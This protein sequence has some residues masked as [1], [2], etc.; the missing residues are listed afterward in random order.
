MI[1][2]RRDE[3]PIPIPVAPAGWLDPI[4]RCP[5][6]GG[7]LEGYADP[8]GSGRQ[9]DRCHQRWVVVG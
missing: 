3:P 2:S 7:V 4:P 8:R 6:C 5:L 9:C 1:A